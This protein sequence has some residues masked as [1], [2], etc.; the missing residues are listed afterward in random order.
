ML[1]KRVLSLGMPVVEEPI[2]RREHLND[3]RR[4]DDLLAQARQQAQRILDEAEQ[5]ARH[6]VERA[7]GQF[8]ADA[9]TFLQDLEEE[10]KAFRRE[11]LDTVDHLLNEAMTRLLDDASLPER[12]RA[13]LRDLSASQPIASAATLSCHPELAP[14]VQDWLEQSRFAQLWQVQPNNAMPSETLV[15]SHASGA[16]EVDWNTLRAGLMVSFE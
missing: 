8:W 5:E 14:T 2:L 12:I 15:L 16:F 1:A 3:V 9:N 7:T 13:L 10:R 4:A 11:A 6:Q